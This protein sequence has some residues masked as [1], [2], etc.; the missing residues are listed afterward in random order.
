MEEII[1]SQMSN[2][3]E[4]IEKHETNSPNFKKEKWCDVQKSNYHD[5]NECFKQRSSI[6]NLDNS[7]NKTDHTN[8]HESNA[9]IIPKIKYST[10][11]QV[12]IGSRIYD[13]LLDSGSE[14]S[15]IKKNIVKE[16]N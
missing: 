5:N 2:F 12:K 11:V 13:A 14:I 16:M 1:K 3:P 9:I 10:Y 4:K 15:I 6:R 7:R 8:K